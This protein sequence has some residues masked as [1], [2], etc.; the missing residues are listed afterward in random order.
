M[1]SLIIGAALAVLSVPAMAQQM[2]CG[3][4]DKVIN[5]IAGKFGETRQSIGLHPR[6]SIVE[7]Y[8]NTET[9]TWTIV[10]TTPGGRSCLMSAGQ[11]FQNTSGDANPGTPS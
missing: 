11:S 2:P 9:G 5:G 4:R 3:P 6:G 8:A 10:V 7:V 1:R